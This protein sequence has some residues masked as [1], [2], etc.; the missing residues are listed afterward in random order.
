MAEAMA[1]QGPQAS[2]DA[3]KAVS[4][5][6]ASAFTA[7][8]GLLYRAA[9][10]ATTCSAGTPR[11]PCGEGEG[12]GGVCK[13]VL[14]KGREGGGRAVCGKSVMERGE[15]GEEWEK[16]YGRREYYGGES[17]EGCSLPLTLT[18]LAPFSHPASPSASHPPSV[19]PSPS[20]EYPC[21]GA[22]GCLPS[23]DA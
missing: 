12:G 8:S 14:W 19:A 2:L 10:A 3:A 9:T 17:E 6:L 15:L 13:G 1:V 16:Y 22:S 18:S 11:R 20:A 5:A 21:H 7:G 4:Q 23:P